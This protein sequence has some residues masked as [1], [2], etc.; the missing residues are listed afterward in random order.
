MN[1]DA[2]VFWVERAEYLKCLSETLP[3][4]HMYSTAV[5]FVISDIYVIFVCHF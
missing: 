1:T 3:I 4:V 5:V 2:L